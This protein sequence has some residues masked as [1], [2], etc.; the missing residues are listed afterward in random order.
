MERWICTDDDREFV[1]LKE[2]IPNADFFFSP[3]DVLAKAG[4]Q[5][6]DEQVDSKINSILRG[7]YALVNSSILG[8]SLFMVLPSDMVGR[9][10]LQA[11]TATRN[12]MFDKN[13]R[14]LINFRH[15][16]MQSI[17]LYMK[18]DNFDEEKLKLTIDLLADS[19]FEEKAKGRAEARWKRVREQFGNLLKQNFSNIPYS[20]LKVE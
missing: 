6:F 9:R 2:L 12:K 1:I 5:V 17:E 13:P 19:V 7:D 10:D 8:D 20:K 18:N 14:I 4:H 15:D 11:H 3:K 16:L